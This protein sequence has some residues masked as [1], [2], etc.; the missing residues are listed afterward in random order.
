[1]KV[2]KLV[3][4]PPGVMIV[5][6]LVIAA[7]GTVAVTCVA[8]LT[9]NVAVT[10]PNVTFVVC[11][12][13]VP[14]MTTCVPTAPLVGL[15]LEMVGMTLKIWLLVRMPEGVVTLTDPVVPVTGTTAVI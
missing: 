13:P 9:T 12:N 14:L 10:S 5:I 8:E 6:L 7:V 2:P 11:V 15:K 1:M 3:A 4:T